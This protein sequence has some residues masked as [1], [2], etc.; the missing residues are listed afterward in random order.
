[1]TADHVANKFSLINSRYLKEQAGEPRIMMSYAEQQLVLAEARILG[2]ITTST[3]KDY[4]ETGVKSAL[5]HMLAV[6]SSYA[7]GKPIDAAYIN[8][9]FTG[10]AAFKTN[11][12]D[13][14]K[15]IW[16]QRYLMNFMQNSESTYFEYRR[17]KYPVFPINPSTSL[18][19]NNKEGVPMRYLYPGSETN[20]NREN[21]IEAL[22]RQYEGFDEINKVMW[23]LK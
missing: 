10:E 9:Y 3:A 12:D 21:L 1:M 14:L 20:F 23:V 13:Q 19:E 6:K 5:S 8:G 16:M 17:T 7:H 2:W 22:D 15:Q 18:N 11:P 4:Y